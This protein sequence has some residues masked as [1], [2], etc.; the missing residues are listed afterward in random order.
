MFKY[1]KYELKGTMKFLIGT[2]IL[3][4]GAS[5][6]IQLYIKGE[7]SNSLGYMGGMPKESAF[8]AFFLL[9][10][11]FIFIGSLVAVMV[12]L[13]S[14]YRREL[15]EDRGYLTF[16]L[17]LS[18]SQLLGSKLIVALFWG[19]VM[20]IAIIAYNYLLVQVLMGYNFFEYFW[21]VIRQI[22]NWGFLLTGSIITSI[23][24]TAV[25]L[26]L[27]YFA[28]TV[29]RVSIKSRKIG[30]MW[31]V[32]FIILTSVITYIQEVITKQLPMYL[33]LS[34]MKIIGQQEAYI[35]GVD[36]QFTGFISMQGVVSLPGLLFQIALIVGIFFATAYMLDRKID[37]V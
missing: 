19:T 34:T 35:M 18:G 12:Y 31:F 13:I 21:A 27:I 25:T 5:T 1:A 9:A 15:Y 17:P 30:S 28:I 22:E 11:V 29:S 7:A 33:D 37:I 6:G 24:E 8:T 20:G 36:S 2:I 23:M 16:S 4:L 10:L 32:L 14:S 26:L 3:A